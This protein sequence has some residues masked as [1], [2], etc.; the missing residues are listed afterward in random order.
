MSLKSAHGVRLVLVLGQLAIINLYIPLSAGLT[1]N[2]YSIKNDPT[3]LIVSRLFISLKPRNCYSKLFFIGCYINLK[4]IPI[5]KLDC[6][7]QN[8]A[9]CKIMD[10]TGYRT[11]SITR[12]QIAV[13]M[14]KTDGDTPVIPRFVFEQTRPEKD[15]LQNING[16]L[17]GTGIKLELYL[18]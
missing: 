2:G 14:N 13:W 1:L 8:N 16:T 12:Q 5:S 15:N 11:I 6:Q 17:K 10:Q 4:N 18:V 3:P 7:E 9:I